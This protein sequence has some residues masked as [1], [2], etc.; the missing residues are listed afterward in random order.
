MYTCI[1]FSSQN[2][3]RHG[4]AEERET[5]GGRGH[6]ETQQHRRRPANFIYTASCHQFHSS[7]G[8]GVH[9]R[10]WNG[11]I[12]RS[13][14]NTE[15]SRSQ[16]WN[17][18]DSIDCCGDGGGCR[19]MG[20]SPGGAPAV[21]AAAAARLCRPSSLRVFPFFRRSRRPLLREVRR[22]RSGDSTARAHC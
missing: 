9:L 19:A 11:R 13:N 20:S 14:N 10:S 7:T 12:N 3:R 17:R 1:H 8:D 4:Q 22:F 6:R 16:R 15:L 18:L 21:A 5:G 2:N